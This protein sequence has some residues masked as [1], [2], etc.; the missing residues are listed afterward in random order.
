MVFIPPLHCRSDTLPVSTILV[1]THPSL[2]LL[3]WRPRTRCGLCGWACWWSGYVDATARSRGSCPRCCCTP[4]GWRR[5]P[6]QQWTSRSPSRHPPPLGTGAGKIDS[7]APALLW[8]QKQLRRQGELNVCKSWHKSS[9]C[10]FK[11]CE[12]YCSACN[13]AFQY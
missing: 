9:L 2:C 5:R 3:G 8:G 10:S 1:Y 6:S 7:W 11:H 4:K 12:K 13:L